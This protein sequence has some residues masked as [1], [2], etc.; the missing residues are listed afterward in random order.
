M[1]LLLVQRLSDGRLY[2]QAVGI[3]LY[4]YLYTF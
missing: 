4:W 1:H 2:L 3:H